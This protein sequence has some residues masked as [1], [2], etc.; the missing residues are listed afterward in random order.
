MVNDTYWQRFITIIDGYGIIL[1]I[2]EWKCRHFANGISNQAK[3]KQTCE[4]IDTYWNFNL[5]NDFESKNM[6]I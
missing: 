6:F 5:M 2:G 1:T 3:K 4:I